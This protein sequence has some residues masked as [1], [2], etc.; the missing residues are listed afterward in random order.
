MDEAR[1]TEERTDEYALVR[2]AGEL[3][4]NTAP[5]LRRSL[6]KHVRHELP[7]LLLDLSELEFMDTSGL[8]TIIESHLSVQRYG[9]QV[10]LFGMPGQIRE[11][12]QVTGVEK[13]FT[14][15]ESEQ[16]AL[17]HIGQDAD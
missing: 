6:N 11:V 9:G 4:I 7:A 16:A 1:V 10:V 8:A 13:I 12:F 2:I 3:N 14:I 5:D 15:L 17:Q